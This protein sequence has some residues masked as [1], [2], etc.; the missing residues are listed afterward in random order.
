M[1]RLT[2]LNRFGKTGLEPGHIGFEPD[3]VDVGQI[4]RHDL[5]SSRL[6]LRTLGR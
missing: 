3:R 2:L 4:V 1:Q 5:Q 6:G